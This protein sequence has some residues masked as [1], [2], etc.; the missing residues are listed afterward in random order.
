MKKI[1]VCL[2]MFLAGSFMFSEGI[3]L[4]KFDKLSESV[5]NNYDLVDTST[6][7]NTELEDYRIII[8]ENG[9]CY[10]FIGNSCT[11]YQ[12]AGTQKIFDKVPED[13]WCRG[14]DPLANVEVKVYTLENS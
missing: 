11:L 6:L 9:I 7:E 3:S 12:K 8:A 5:R 4:E 2:A 14:F 1:L 10:M 13:I